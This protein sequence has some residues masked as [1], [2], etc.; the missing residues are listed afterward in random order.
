[1]HDKLPER[2]QHVA[3][4]LPYRMRQSLVSIC[5][6]AV[7]FV[8]SPVLHGD[9]DCE[10]AY[11]ILNNSS[12]V[13]IEHRKD[14]K[15]S[16]PRCEGISEVSFLDPSDVV[17]QDVP[18]LTKLK[19]PAKIGVN[20][21]ILKGKHAKQLAAQATVLRKMREVRIS[22]DSDAPLADIN[23]F[24][25]AKISNLRVLTIYGGSNPRITDKGLAH[26]K[27]LK[28][29][30][31]LTLSDTDVTDKGLVNLGGM[32]ALRSLMIFSP[33]VTGEG[34]RNLKPLPRL[35]VLVIHGSIND[36]S[37]RDVAAI[38]TLQRLK[39]TGKQLT[40]TG[41]KHLT[42]LKALEFLGIEDAKI[43]EDGLSYL[44][45]LPKLKRLALVG[46][47]KIT[48]SSV[49]ALGQ[50]KALRELSVWETGIS[51]SGLSRLKK[52]LPDTKIEYKAMT[53]SR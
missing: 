28:Q 11:D 1:M 47:Q 34:F 53:S 23:L 3:I 30:E 17:I 46:C 20:F 48:D 6:F 31:Y 49:E 18:Y 45:E 12:G 39:I 29:L 19:D 7:C 33:N 25:L 42:S 37:I 32:D 35:K 9:D 44:T 2:E 27:N 10:K 8:T 50:L 13:L 16:A 40:N 14:H 43:D 36:K 5:V 38:S 52:L 4:G 41:M 26:L 15:A 21:S 22:S 24:E 51:A